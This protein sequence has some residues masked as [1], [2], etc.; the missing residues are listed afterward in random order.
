MRHVLSVALLLLPL[1]AMADEPE[2]LCQPVA[3]LACE[4]TACESV[5]PAIESLGFRRSDGRISFCEL[6]GCYI[7]RVTLD[8]EGWP[9]PGPDLKGL[10]TVE[11]DPLP[12]PLA[13]R[14]WG[15]AF[16]PATGRLAMT[17]LGSERQ[18]ITWMQCAQ[19]VH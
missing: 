6:A 7:G 8:H 1:S 4:T 5:R 3:T 9:D 15:V 16:D 10:A 19:P 18:E 13:T 14:F 2:W 12:R 17:R 11:P